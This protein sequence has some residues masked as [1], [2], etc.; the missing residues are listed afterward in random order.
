[1]V[2]C[3]V[4]A[5]LFLFSSVVKKFMALL[6]SV[7]VVKLIP[8][9]EYGYIVYAMTILAFF[10]PF[11][12]F[13]I[14]FSLLRFGSIQNRLQKKFDLYYDSLRRGFLYSI[15]LVFIMALISPIVAYNMPGAQRYIVILSFSLISALFFNNYTILLRIINRNK[16]FALSVIMYSLIT[17]GLITLSGYYFSA[18]GYVWAIS[19]GPLICFIIIT[20]KTLWKTFIHSF[21]KISLPIINPKEYLKYGVYVGFGSV[22]SQNDLINR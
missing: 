19:L 9:N 14:Q 15:P 1:M 17:F 21:R 12:G 11:S 8:Q 2:F 16:S 7:F 22:A 4:K 13:G 5:I 20:R 3:N 10:T 18:I 6:T